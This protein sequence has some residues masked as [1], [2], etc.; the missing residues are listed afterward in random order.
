[1]TL[2]S[3]LEMDL[4]GLLQPQWFYIFLHQINKIK[5]NL[6]FLLTA[7]IKNKSHQQKKQESLQSS[8]E[9]INNRQEIYLFN[10]I[11][12]FK[13]MDRK[14]MKRFSLLLVLA[15]SISLTY[16][17]TLNPMQDKSSGLWGYVNE[18]GKWITKPKYTKVHPFKEN[19]LGRVE[20]D[21]AIGYV[22]QKGKEVLKCKYDAQIE[23]PD[24]IFVKSK[25]WESWDAY[26]LNEQ[27]KYDCIFSHNNLRN[28]STRDINVSLVPG[29][30]T[31]KT[32]KE[33]RL[34]V[35][36]NGKSISL[37][38]ETTIENRNN[39]YFI[40]DGYGYSTYT[41]SGKF[42]TKI[43]NE[44]D[45]PIV[46]TFKNGNIAL[47]QCDTL[48]LKTPT[49]ASEKVNFLF[50]PDLKRY[51]IP[52]AFDQL[53]QSERPI[54]KNE[55]GEYLFFSNQFADSV[56]YETINWTT[57]DADVNKIS[58]YKDGKWD[59]YDGEKFYNM[60]IPGN[61]DE[62][63]KLIYWNDTTFI[64]R[65]GD[66]KFGLYAYEKQAYLISDCDNFSSSTKSNL[67]CQKDGTVGFID[68]ENRKIII[69]PGVYSKIKTN[70]N[71]YTVKKNGKWGVISKD[72]S[73]TLI[74]FIYDDMFTNNSD[75]GCY[76]VSK[77]N[78]FGAINANT[79]KI[80]VPIKYTSV[81]TEKDF[82]EDK[83]L[84]RVKIGDNIGLYFKG[85]EILPCK[86]YSPVYNTGGE[87]IYN[88][89]F[90][91]FVK[92]SHGYI[93][94]IDFNGKVLVPFSN[95]YTYYDVAPRNVIFSKQS[96]EQ[97]RVGW[98]VY[99]FA[100]KKMI[101]SRVFDMDDLIGMKYALMP[102]YK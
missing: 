46:Q 70:E 64:I 87:F 62:S 32:V 91:I 6:K 34:F 43:Y 93:G 58:V 68:I 79:G 24:Y 59:F 86:K 28:D 40:K 74:P 84:Y 2:I 52:V 51:I 15:S 72:G 61:K 95:K 75:N 53:L 102:Y 8:K 14:M 49:H 90:G 10:Q 19:K 27:Y 57:R 50:T 60:N 21:G 12:I 31:L 82:G 7:A 47:Y 81:S 100:N 13:I 42:L 23:T 77:N 3:P 37:D 73:K 80:I 36:S 92:D 71:S 69:E 30:F 11:Q 101:Y 67:L 48:S 44:N 99:S 29:L 56:K 63:G 98:Y 35:F 4:K 65:Q 1:M 22:N 41:A 85:K 83:I 78:K 94:A 20:K 66:K 96:D 25:G 26:D 9:S 18:S 38:K 17:Q 5:I 54:L 39:I 89:F 97:R 76:I 55:K 45:I 33:L 88:L 16:S